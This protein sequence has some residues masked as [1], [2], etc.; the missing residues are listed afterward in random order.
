[1]SLFPHWARGAVLITPSY[2]GVPE[3][4]AGQGK[5]QLVQ[6]TAGVKKRGAGDCLTRIKGH[7]KHRAPL[8]SRKYVLS[9]A[10]TVS[11]GTPHGEK[12]A[13]EAGTLVT[14]RRRKK[15]G[16]DAGTGPQHG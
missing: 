13:G 7:S 16:A 12:W 14:G 4:T 10:G 9:I 2:R 11:I 6:P 8:L 5:Y 3:G 15:A 1:M